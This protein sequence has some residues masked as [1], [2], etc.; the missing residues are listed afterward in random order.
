MIVFIL[1]CQLHNPCVSLGISKPGHDTRYRFNYFYML[2]LESNIMKGTIVPGIY[3]DLFYKDEY[4]QYDPYGSGMPLTLRAAGAGLQF[5]LK[6]G[7]N[8]DF[9]FKLLILTITIF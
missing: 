3:T 6:P 5:K 7:Q 8:I 2:E 1:V 4:M 9:A